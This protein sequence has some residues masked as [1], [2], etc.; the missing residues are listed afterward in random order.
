M[1][2]SGQDYEHN[3]DWEDYDTNPSNKFSK[4]MTI[5]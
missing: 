1:V 2:E 3:V 5:L 4:L